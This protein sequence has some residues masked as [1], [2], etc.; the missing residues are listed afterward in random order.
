MTPL[1]PRRRPACRRS[2]WLA[3]ISLL[4]T[5]ACGRASA[6]ETEPKSAPASA[7]EEAPQSLDRAEAQLEQA[8]A[9]LEQIQGELGAQA[10][11]SRQASPGAGQSPP[12]APA[13]TQAAAPAAESEGARPEARSAPKKAESRELDV[14]KDDAVPAEEAPANRLSSCER[15][16]KAFGSLQR[17]RDA[18][19]RLDEQGGAR[20]ARADG[21]LQDAAS[22][23]QSCGCPR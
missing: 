7:A 19:C 5:A 8:R 23:V 1:A 17:A 21:I 12:P 9:E 16:C 2:L 15:S 3:L 4:V 14:A 13:T 6:P 10:T 20:C 22:K 18:V 11:L